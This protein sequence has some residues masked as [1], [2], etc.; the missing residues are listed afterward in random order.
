MPV[1]SI[2]IYLY[3]YVIIYIFIIYLCIYRKNKGIIEKYCTDS[4]YNV[5]Y[6]K[7]LYSNAFEDEGEER[8]YGLR[9]AGECVVLTNI[10]NRSFEIITL[11]I[12]KVCASKR[13]ELSMIDSK[14]QKVL[15]K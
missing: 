3:I 2:R 5:E 13:G 4:I 6:Y 15:L 8:P 9:G 10:I 7:L 1:V 11:I 14:R 12:R